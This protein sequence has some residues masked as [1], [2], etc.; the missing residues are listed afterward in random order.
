LHL[1]GVDASVLPLIE[2]QAQGRNPLTSNFARLAP[3][4][5]LVS[6]LRPG[7]E[8]QSIKRFDGLLDCGQVG[9]G[10]DDLEI[11]AAESFAPPFTHF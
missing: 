9:V 5:D 10:S 6:A 7:A 8:L 11:G 3:T 4:K 2:R 1:N